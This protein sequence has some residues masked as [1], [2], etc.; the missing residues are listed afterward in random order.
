MI[1]VRGLTVSAGA[2][3]LASQL[4]A[5]QVV[6]SNFCAKAIAELQKDEPLTNAAGS[7]TNNPVFNRGYGPMLATI[8][9][10]A[11]VMC[12]RERK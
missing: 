11:E 3:L 9:T 4:Q 10:P 1:H 2:L 5:Q 6:S 12:E 7:V 8:A